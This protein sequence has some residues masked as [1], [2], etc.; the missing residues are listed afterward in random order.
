MTDLLRSQDKT[1]MDEELLLTDGQR[2][3]LLETEPTPGK[4]AVK[5]MK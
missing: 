4:D 5:I 2:K 3:W 1:A